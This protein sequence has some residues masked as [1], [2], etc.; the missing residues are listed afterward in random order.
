M[1][2]Q[3][4]YLTTKFWER[5]RIRYSSKSTQKPSTCKS[6]PLTI[7]FFFPSLDSHY[8]RSN[9]LSSRAPSIFSS[10]S[11]S[12][13]HAYRILFTFSTHSN[14]GLS[15]SLITT[16]LLFLLLSCSFFLTLSH[17]PMH[18]H[19]HPSSIMYF[20]NI[21][22]SQTAILY[23]LPWIIFKKVYWV[24]D[25]S[26]FWPCFFLLFKVRV[27]LRRPPCPLLSHP[28][29]SASSPTASCDS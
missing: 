17:I 27:C 5:V 28:L 4:I 12:L 20:L 15:L 29:R 14:Y 1:T 2:S 23:F 8:L 22:I 3:S 18:K 25:D 6:L 10:L 21:F 9:L 11:P 24:T 7:F 26:K 13:L 19:T 16:G